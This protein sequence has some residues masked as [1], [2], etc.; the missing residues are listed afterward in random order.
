MTQSRRSGA[1]GGLRAKAGHTGTVTQSTDADEPFIGRASAAWG[2]TGFACYWLLLAALGYLAGSLERSWWP[3]GGAVVATGFYAFD[4][5]S[6]IRVAGRSLVA[7]NLLWRRVIDLDS[8]TCVQIKSGFGI[9]G[10]LSAVVVHV[11]DR[12][13]AL[14]PSIRIGG[15]KLWHLRRMVIDAT[16]LSHSGQRTR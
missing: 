5:T 7:R 12:R 8:V 15:P 6:S 16:E 4:V 11:G 13:F 9:F 1:R 10:S 14:R 2:A 3:A